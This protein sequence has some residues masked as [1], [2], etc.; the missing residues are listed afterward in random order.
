MSH[1]SHMTKNLTLAIS[2]ELGEKMKEHN[3]VRW[4]EVARQAIER[5]IRDLETLEKIAS[6]SRLTKKDV[7]EISRKINKETYAEMKRR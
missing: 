2:D 3:D 1:K 6:K 7:E 4:S 5:K